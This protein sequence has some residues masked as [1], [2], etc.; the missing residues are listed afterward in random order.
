LRI[1]ENALRQYLSGMI[2]RRDQPYMPIH[3]GPTTQSL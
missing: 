2:T 1:A 3:Y